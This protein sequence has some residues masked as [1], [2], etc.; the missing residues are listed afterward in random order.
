MAKHLTVVGAGPGVGMAVAR[1]FGREG[2]RVSLLARNGA[3]LE[4]FE[5]ELSGLGI[6]ARGFPTDILDHER[7]IEALGAA[8]AAFGPVDVLQFSPAS[9]ADASEGLPRQVDADTVRYQFELGVVG[10]VVAVRQVLPDMLERGDGAVLACAAPSSKYPMLFSSPYGMAS[11]ALRQYIHLLHDDL[12]P[13]GVYAGFVIIAGLVDKGDVPDPDRE[14]T[15]E[16]APAVAIVPAGDVAEEL[17]KMSTE[18]V[19]TET[20]IGDMDAIFGVIEG[21][22][23]APRPGMG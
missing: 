7:L 21:M 23:A 17:W 4:G 15:A 1:R 13:S 19:S 2:F 12:A 16:Q 9:G 22:K 6:E 20:V 3:A 10:A 18:R 11:S 8:R 14:A 5:Q